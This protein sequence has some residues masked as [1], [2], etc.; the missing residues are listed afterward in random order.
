MHRVFNNLGKCKLDMIFFMYRLI[1]LPEV[2]QL[3]LFHLE[4]APSSADP[5]SPFD[6]HPHHWTSMGV[7]VGCL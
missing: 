4:T 1:N 6:V 2:Q 5:L 7:T 3:G